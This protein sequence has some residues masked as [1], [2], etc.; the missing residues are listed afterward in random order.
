M[1]K[2]SL[3]AAIAENNVIGKD[4]QMPWHLPDDLKW[5]KKHTTGCDVIMGKNTFYSLPVRPLPKRKNIVITRSNEAIDGCV[6]ASSIED[7][8]EKM[9]PEKENF[10]IG[11]GIIF[12]QF[13]SIAQ[14]LYITKVHHS[15][16]GDTFFPQIDPSVW[17][18][19]FSEEHPAD[20]K[21]AYS[22]TFQVYEKP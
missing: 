3:I 16:E 18:L 5:F 17:K 13:M 19:T 7:A 11:G 15:F 21:H 6:M 22:F 10:V 8:I 1:K 14:K 2:I 9:E 20:E 4:N 12:E